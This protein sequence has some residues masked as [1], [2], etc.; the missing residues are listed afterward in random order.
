MGFID[1][2]CDNS[3]MMMMVDGGWWMDFHDMFDHDFL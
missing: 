1:D 3:I 2:E